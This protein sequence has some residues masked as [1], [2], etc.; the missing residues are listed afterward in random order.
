M[1]GGNGGNGGNGDAGDCNAV[2]GGGGGGGAGGSGGGV[3]VNGNAVTVNGTLRANGGAGGDGGAAGEQYD[4]QECGFGE[5]GSSGGSGGGGRLK[6][7]GASLD[8][9]G[10]TLSVT[11]ASEGTT[12]TSAGIS[13]Y[14]VGTYTSGVIDTGAA[15]V[16][17]RTISWTHSGGQI[18]G[19]KARSANASNMSGATDW[20]S[21]TAIVNGGTLASGGCV[22]DGHRYIQYQATFITANNAITPSLDDVSII[23]TR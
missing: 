21:C 3:F 4:Y 17:W 11:G 18:L 16:A 22:T 6:L 13:Y 20:N 1:N 5:N 19:L 23:Y 15:T 8:S 10:A 14:L 7:F 9:S 12:Y 2:P